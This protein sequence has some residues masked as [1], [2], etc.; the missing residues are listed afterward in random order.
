MGDSEVNNF[1]TAEDKAILSESGISQ[2]L[3]NREI[4]SHFEPTSLV[5]SCQ[6]SQLHV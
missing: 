1:K 2:E 5:S 6:T 4:L 3:K